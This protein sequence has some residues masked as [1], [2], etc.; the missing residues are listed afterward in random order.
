MTREKSSEP[1]NIKTKKLEKKLKAK[2]KI[3]IAH[4][5]RTI[6]DAVNHHRLS[7]LDPL[8][9]KFVVFSPKKG[10]RTIAEVGEDNVCEQVSFDYVVDSIVNYL[11]KNERTR[12]NEYYALEYR[13]I[14]ECAKLWL[15]GAPLVEEPRPFRFRDD[16]G[17]TYSRLPWDYN[18][19]GACPL[20]DEIFSRM[21][22]AQAALNF[23]GSLFFPGNH[24]Q[25]YLY[26]YGEG[27]NGKGAIVR[28][29]ERIFGNSAASL[30]VPVDPSGMVKDPYFAAKLL[31]KRFVYF[32]ELSVLNFPSSALFKR[33][34]GND[35]FNINQKF[36]PEYQNKVD[37]KFVFTSNDAP[38]LYGADSDRRR[39]I[40]CFIE[41]AK[42]HES[43]RPYEDLLWDEGGGFIS[44]CIKNYQETCEP[45]LEIPCDHS[46]F[47]EISEDTDRPYER[48]FE[49]LF[50]EVDP[51]GPHERL[52][53]CELHDLLS[54]RGLKR[55]GITLFKR[56]LARE[57]KHKLER[58]DKKIDP[59]QTRYFPRLKRRS[60][61][62]SNKNSTNERSRYGD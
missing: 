19:E 33:F 60:Y 27:R 32:D 10:A 39:A 16:P 61:S 34:T 41:K 46:L 52:K 55:G 21:S 11:Q 54:D 15:S 12:D 37:A 17:L 36:K 5:Y 31:G 9:E 28:F 57:K 18:P 49:I 8:P 14:R 47:E 40:I 51:G 59:A 43:E 38:I 22:N 29:L 30:D 2:P 4:I 42:P 6:A 25:Q 35:S 53:N 13:Q 7:D 26:L 20:F 3:K 45:H 24:R 1:V 50:D 56:W 44:R 23:I 58:F 48:M 62:S